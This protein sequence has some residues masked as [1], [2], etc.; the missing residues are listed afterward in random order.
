MQSQQIQLKFRIDVELDRVYRA[1][2]LELHE[3][4]EEGKAEQGGLFSSL[5]L[6]FLAI[7]KSSINIW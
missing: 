3:N 4:D 1:P 7:R 5:N 2:S 6:L